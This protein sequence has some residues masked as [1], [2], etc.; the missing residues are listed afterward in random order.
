MSESEEILIKIPFDRIKDEPAPSFEQFS[1]FYREFGKLLT[2]E[3][4]EVPKCI[5][6]MGQ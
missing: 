1:I 6:K 4:R 5:L 2:K 3:G